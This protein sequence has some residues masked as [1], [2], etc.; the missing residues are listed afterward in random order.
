MKLALSGCLDYFGSKNIEWLNACY[1]V[2]IAGKQ[3]Q[4]AP[5]VCFCEDIDLSWGD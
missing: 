5:N 3:S 1:I 4:S 2:L